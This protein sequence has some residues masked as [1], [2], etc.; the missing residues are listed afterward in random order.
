MNG[1]DSFVVGLLTGSLTFFLFDFIDYV[2]FDPILKQEYTLEN[3][4]VFFNGQ[5]FNDSIKIELN[6]GIVL[7]IDNEGSRKK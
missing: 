7:N 6:D 5:E 1:L 2:Y 4:K 3:G